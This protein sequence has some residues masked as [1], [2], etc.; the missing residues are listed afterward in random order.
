MTS[1]NHVDCV[2]EIL[3]KINLRER[4]TL[5]LVSKAWAEAVHELDR[6]QKCLTIIGRCPLKRPDGDNSSNQVINWPGHYMRY[7]CLEAILARFRALRSLTFE[8]I[9]PWNDRRLLELTQQCSRLQCLSFV[10]CFDL[11]E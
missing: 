2:A 10:R 11:G 7:T 5:R 4:Q 3:S 8:C 6:T 1:Y 9:D